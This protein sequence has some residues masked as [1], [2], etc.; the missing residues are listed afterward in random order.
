M[1]NNKKIS[2]KATALILFSG[3]NIG[4]ALTSAPVI[5]GECITLTASGGGSICIDHG[6]YIGCSKTITL[7][8]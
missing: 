8:N 4:I 5:A 6:D 1:L 2:T 7:C 3:L